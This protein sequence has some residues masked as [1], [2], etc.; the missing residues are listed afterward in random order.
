MTNASHSWIVD[1][2]ATNHVCCS[3]QG[4]KETKRLE[5]NEFSFSWRNGAVVAA[6]AVGKLVLNLSHNKFL[7]L[8][9][10]YYVPD[11]GKNL[12]SVSK[13]I[14]DGY[15]LIFNND[16][17]DILRNNLIICKAILFDNLFYL[18]PITPTALNTETNTTDHRDKRL[19]MDQNNLT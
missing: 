2:G 14:S 18:R 5:D 9:D 8:R 13:L 7:I 4:F 6:A 16:G 17:I 1:S 19:K 11:F 3:L 15:D 10:V 12:V